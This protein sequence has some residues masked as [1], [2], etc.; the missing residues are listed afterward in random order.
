MRPSGTELL[1]R[2]QQLRPALLAR[3]V[4]AERLHR[5]PAATIAEFR[6]AGIFRVIR[7]VA[8]AG[9]ETDFIDQTETRRSKWQRFSGWA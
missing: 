2:A 5:L 7:P 3:Q 6:E 1:G 9:F 4:E 8:F